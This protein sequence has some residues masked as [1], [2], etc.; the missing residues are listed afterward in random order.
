MKLCSTCNIQRQSERWKHEYLEGRGARAEDEPV[1]EVTAGQRSS[2]VS[3]QGGK[4]E[5]EENE[6]RRRHDHRVELQ[7]Q[8][9]LGGAPFKRAERE[10][11]REEEDFCTQFK[12]AA[13]PHELLAGIY[14]SC[15]CHLIGSLNFLRD[16]GA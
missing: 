8:S 13:P 10:M 3:R 14:L 7:C 15:G 16:V 12:R 1:G 2:G 5:E 6:E 11:Q 9:L 4:A